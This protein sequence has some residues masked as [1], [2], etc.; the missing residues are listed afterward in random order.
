MGKYPK[1]LGKHTLNTPKKWGNTP[2]FWGSTFYKHLQLR[3]LQASKKLRN[4]LYNS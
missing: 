3:Y 2:K 1:N 4:Y